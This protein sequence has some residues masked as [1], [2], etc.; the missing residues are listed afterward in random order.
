MGKPLL[1]RG[2]GW[3]RQREEKQA[4]AGRKSP[5]SHQ[6]SEVEE[7][8]DEGNKRA[9]LSESLI[10]VKTQ[11]AWAKSTLFTEWR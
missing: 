4:E 11:F 6:T 5:E 7:G 2:R 3:G 8:R 1:C 9:V 10:N